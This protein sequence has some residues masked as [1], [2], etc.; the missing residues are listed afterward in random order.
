V[1]EYIQ[2]RA[3]FADIVD[4]VKVTCMPGKSTQ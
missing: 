3:L 2:R 1:I 4:I